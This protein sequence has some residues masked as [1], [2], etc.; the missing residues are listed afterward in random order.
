MSAISG[1]T[2]DSSLRTEIPF[3]FITN[4]SAYTAAQAPQPIH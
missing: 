1:V 3:S 2:V 4:V